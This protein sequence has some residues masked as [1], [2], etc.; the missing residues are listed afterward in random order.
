ML[1]LLMVALCIWISWYYGDVF[2]MARERSFWVA[3]SKQMEF[4]LQQ[5]YGGLWYIGRMMLSLFRYP[6]AGGAVLALM[7]TAATWCVGYDLRVKPRLRFIQYIPVGIYLMCIAYEGVNVFLEN[8]GGM[9]TGVPFCV[10]LILVIWA[11][12]IRSFSRKPTP[13]MIGIPQDE[14]RTDNLLQ[15][16]MAVIV[17]AVPTIFIQLERP[18]TRV[19]AS[20]SVGVIEQDWQR[21]MKVARDNAELSY[22]PMAAPYAIALV[23]TDQLNDRLYDIRL[24]YDSIYT[25]GRGGSFNTGLALYQE[26]CDFHAGLIQTCIHHAIER[27]TM[28]GPNIHSMELLVKC[29]LMTG[30][31]E[32][33]RKYLRILRDVPFEGDFISKYSP[34]VGNMEMVDADPEIAM[35]RL[36]EP[37][38]DNLENNLPQPTFMGYNSQLVEGRSINALKQSLAVCAYTKLMPAFMMRTQPLEGT[39]PPQNI[40]DALCLMSSKDPGIPQRFTGLDYRMNILKG[41]LN[42]VGDKIKATP[43]MT[44]AQNRELHAR[45][46]FDSYRGYYPYYYF[47]GNL[48]ATRKS[49]EYSSSNAGVN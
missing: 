28:I 6:W 1:P 15:V 39:T 43:T 37:M 23:H 49:K 9:L 17:I 19:I 13:A 46:L 41:F 22:R 20:E 24:D 44:S 31:W 18:Y 26:D 11:V 48:K 38:H 2:R 40:A 16:A 47:F 7:L 36:T 45:E 25:H 14:T 21:I 5:E 12:M 30:E 3:D 29:H 35:L 8:E 10:T 32:A 33:A 34:M 4:L 27:I 42:S